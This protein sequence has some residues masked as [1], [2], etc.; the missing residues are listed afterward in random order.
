MINDLKKENYF[1]FYLVPF[2]S[3]MALRMIVSGES[4]WGPYNIAM[5]GLQVRILGSLLLIFCAMPTYDI[6][7]KWSRS[8]DKLKDVL[9]IFVLSPFLY[10]WIV[11]FLLLLFRYFISYNYFLSLYLFSLAICFYFQF[12][13]MRRIKTLLS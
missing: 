4:N 13:F 3:S 12:R 2:L 10:A 8:N 7:I 11:S 9:K 1:V 5:R 6:L